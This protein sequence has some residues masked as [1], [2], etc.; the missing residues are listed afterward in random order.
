MAQRDDYRDAVQTDMYFLARDPVFSSVKPYS[1][2]YPPL[3][4]LPQS[5]IKRDK[6]RMRIKNMRSCATLPS[7]EDCGFGLW[8]FPS[9][10]TY[11]DFADPSKVASVYLKEVAGGLRS[12]MGASWVYIMDFAVCVEDAKKEEVEK[13]VTEL[14]LHRFG[15]ATRP[16]R[17]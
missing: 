1:M 16:L 17:F 7:F 10:M 2:R 15:D 3:R 14:V 12:Q 8:N 11:D 9:K 5:N 6:R 13:S 4:G